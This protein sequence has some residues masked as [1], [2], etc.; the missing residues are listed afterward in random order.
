MSASIIETE[1]T[2]ISE[3]SR[4]EGKVQVERAARI[5]GTIV[6]ELDA[7]AGSQVTLAETGVIEGNVHGDE[8]WIEGFVRGDITA[9]TRVVISST[10]RVVGNVVTPSLQMDFGGYFEGQCRAIR[11]DL[12][13]SPA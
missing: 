10:G 11:E 5:H 6:G 9:T 13:A 12:R 1:I 3:D 7:A 8:L 2:L 4:I